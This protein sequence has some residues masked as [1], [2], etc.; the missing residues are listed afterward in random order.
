MSDPKSH[1]GLCFLGFPG[2]TV[3]LSPTYFNLVIEPKMEF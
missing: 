2:V 3:E 1:V